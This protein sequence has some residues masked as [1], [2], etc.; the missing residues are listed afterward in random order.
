MR[1][2]AFL[3]LFALLRGGFPK[4]SFNTKIVST[5]E[6]NSTMGPWAGF[7]MFQSVPIPLAPSYTL[8]RHLHQEIGIFHR[9]FR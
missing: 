2:S 7:S 3:G 4:F 5:M 9:V 6:K 1:T 8:F